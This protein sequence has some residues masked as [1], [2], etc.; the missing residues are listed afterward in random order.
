M[1]KDKRRRREELSLAELQT[2]ATDA[3]L[4]LAKIDGAE[5][6]RCFKDVLPK[7]E[8]R[9]FMTLVDGLHRH[10]RRFRDQSQV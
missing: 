1:K 8:F 3:G 7:R 4:M 9:E 6:K 10:F 2:K 5:I